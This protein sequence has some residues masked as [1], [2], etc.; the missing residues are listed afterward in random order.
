MIAPMPLRRCL[1]GNTDKQPA[2]NGWPECISTDNDPLYQ[3]KQWK[4]NLRILEIGEIKSLPHVPLSH[5]FVERLIGSIRRELLDQTLFWTATDLENKLRDYQS[6]YNEHRA[7]TGRD[8]ATPVD[9]SSGKVVDIDSY[10][11]KK[12]CRSLFQLPVAA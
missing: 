10:R 7:H 1:P 5:P 3:Y 2:G 8:G 9:S 12:H 6:Y 4:A 11:W